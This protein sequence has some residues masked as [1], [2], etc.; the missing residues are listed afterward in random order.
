MAYTRPLPSLPLHHHRSSHHLPFV[1]ACSKL[2]PKPAAEKRGLEF[3]VTPPCTRP[4][5]RRS[6]SNKGTNMHAQDAWMVFDRSQQAAVHSSAYPRHASAHSG[7]TASNTAHDVLQTLKPRAP[8]I[9]STSTT[10]HTH[11]HAHLSAPTSLIT[12]PRSTLRPGSGGRKSW[13]LDLAGDWPGSG[14]KR[15]EAVEEKAQCSICTSF[16][17]GGSCRSVCLVCLVCRW[18]PIVCAVSLQPQPKA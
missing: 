17:R 18:N 4:V 1:C 5:Q 3:F 6:V 15:S 9:P 10:R 7:N 16:K 13:D 11:N 2:S 12:T 14:G 8:D